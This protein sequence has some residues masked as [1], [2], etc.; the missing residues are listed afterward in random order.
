M[1]YAEI[2]NYENDLVM[3]AYY[4]YY[5]KAKYAAMKMGLD[6]LIND[7]HEAKQVDVYDLKLIL[8]DN[9]I[10]IFIG[11]KRVFYYDP[12]DNEIEVHSGDWTEI[13]DILYQTV[14]DV[15]EEKKAMIK[16]PIK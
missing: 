15:D 4:G 14:I 10:L 5:L 6:I 16:K 1:D 7:E 13:I 12:D 9:V 2:D 8:V 3:K 11:G